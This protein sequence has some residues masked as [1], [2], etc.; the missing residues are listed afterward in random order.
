MPKGTVTPAVRPA[1]GGVSSAPNKRMKYND[2][3]MSQS[4]SRA[5]LTAH[6]GG[7]MLSSS[8]SH[9]HRD[10]SPAKIPG[11]RSSRMVSSSTTSASSLPRPIAMP[12]PKPGTQHHAL[13]H[14]RVPT[15][16]VFVYSGGN[17]PTGLF[18][19]G[20]RSA[21]S[22]ST[23]SVDNRYASGARAAEKKATRA[24]R[25]SFRPRPSM[26]GVDDHRPGTKWALHGFGGLKE[27]EEG[28]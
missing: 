9:K 24:R 14:G 10:V 4:G 19:K 28:Y 5:P 8:S 26:D 7:N 18:P 15:S 21:S 23:G 17:A 11:S 27:E 12:V 3:S 22:T 2:D 6:R 20:I 16:G 25:E 13:G 1:P